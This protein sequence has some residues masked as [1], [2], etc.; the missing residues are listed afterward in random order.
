MGWGDTAKAAL[1]K[2]LEAYKAVV[3]LEALMES[4]L[5]TVDAF[6]RRTNERIEAQNRQSADKLDAF[7]RR[8]RELESRLASVSGKVDGGFT[9]A[10]KVVLLQPEIQRKMLDRSD[11]PSAE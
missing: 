7:E 11:V 1:D 8:I 4:L 6:E 10:I 9:E 5:K 2:A 3:R